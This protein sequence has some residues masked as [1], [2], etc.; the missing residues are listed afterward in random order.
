M[1][2]D[3][4]RVTWYALVMDDKKKTHKDVGIDIEVEDRDSCASSAETTIKYITNKQRLPLQVPVPLN[5]LSRYFERLLQQPG[6]YIT[7]P[8]G[9]NNINSLQTFVPVTPTEIEGLL[10]QLNP[11]EIPWTR[12]DFTV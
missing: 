6:E 2:G 1:R 7:L 5:D 8:Y 10:S 11:P 12:Y 9:P 4:E 3:C